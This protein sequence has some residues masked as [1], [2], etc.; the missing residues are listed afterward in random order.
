MTIRFRELLPEERKSRRYGPYLRHPA[1]T[2]LVSIVNGRTYI[3][4]RQRLDWLTVSPDP[5]WAGDA[6]AYRF[7]AHVDQMLTE[8]Q[9]R[10]WFVLPR[11]NWTELKGVRND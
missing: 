5:E 9:A 7:K 6:A 4:V 2:R 11:L 3:V 1:G 8:E 10:K